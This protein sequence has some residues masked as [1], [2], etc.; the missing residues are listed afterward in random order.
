MKPIEI[1]ELIKDHSPELLG[2]IPDQRAVAIVR[3]ALFQILKHVAI[4]DE[5]TLK[6]PGF[7]QFV[8]RRVAQGE[9][10]HAM[11]KRVI[12]REAP[13]DQA[14]AGDTKAKVQAAAP[15]KAP[16]KKAKAQ[17]AGPKKTPRKN[18]KQE[19]SKEPGTE[20]KKE[21]KPKSGKRSV[22]KKKPTDSEPQLF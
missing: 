20:P 11:V 22:A 19:S 10:S 4:L 2:K 15:K 16:R 18:A 6:I 5:G 21:S 9:D 8:V 3:S 17:A 13:L 12:F 7:G 1:V 14:M